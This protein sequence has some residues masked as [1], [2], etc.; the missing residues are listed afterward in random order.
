[1]V[2]NEYL[3][4]REKQQAEF[5]ALPL[6]AAYGEKQFNEMMAAWGLDPVKDQ[7]KVY[8]LA[9]GMYYLRS[10]AQL[11]RETLKRHQE[12]M[13]KAIAADPTGEGFIFDMFTAEMTNHEYGY[14]GDIGETLDALGLTAEEINGS[15]KLQTGLKLAHKHLMQASED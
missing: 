5:D 3:K 14:T 4:L 8:H 15:E 10:D 1:M 9:A 12:E 7:N 6:K 11:I 13:Q 2:N